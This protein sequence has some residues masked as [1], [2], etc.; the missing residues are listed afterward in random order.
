MS[1]YSLLSNKYF[2]KLFVNKLL[3]NKLKNNNDE[4]KY[5]ISGYGTIFD[6]NIILSPNYNVYLWM[7]SPNP[8][9]QQKLLINE[10]D[11]KLFKLFINKN[12]VISI[13][14][15]LYFVTTKSVLYEDDKIIIIF[16]KNLNINNVNCNFT[17][18]SFFSWF[19]NLFE[20]SNDQ[21]PSI[22]PN[23]Q[24]GPASGDVGW[25]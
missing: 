15:E 20:N 16:D 12:M 14:N 23:L 22:A 4:Y 9:N 7:G 3:V 10:E 11:L 25:F 18:D 24:I 13:N 21:I 1:S 5:Y 2:N 17:I 6:N 8:P 19:D